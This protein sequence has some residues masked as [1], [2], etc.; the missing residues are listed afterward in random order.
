[1][2]RA[3][4]FVALFITFACCAALLLSACSQQASKPVTVEVFSDAEE[5]PKIQAAASVP[6]ASSSPAPAPT[7]E[8]SPIPSP[9]SDFY[10]EFFNSSVFV[11][12]SIT[13]GLQNYVTQMRKDRPMLLGDAKFAAAKSFNLQRACSSRV[14]SD[15]ALRYRGKAM[16][17]PGIIKE[18]GVN[19]VYIMLGVND[20]AGSHID[21]CDT[22][23]RK[24]LDNIRSEV[25]EVNIHVQSCTPVTKAG[26]RA[27]LNNENLDGFNESLRA[28]CQ[29]TGAEYVE[30]S[31]AL[32]GEDNCM[33]PEYSSDHYV[34]VSKD[35]ATAWVNALYQ[36]AYDAYASGAWK[37]SNE[38]SQNQ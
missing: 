17:I 22:L 11:G 31:A 28:I 37:P 18:M 15:G 26:E 13:Q 35:G 38:R 25:P 27:K 8:P 21:E 5:T 10:D 24:L 36:Y 32:K 23:Y 4:V 16:T 34:H 7:P 29:D 30:I 20:W 19:N 3:A 2:K 9:G 14:P 12:D 33:K 6:A 1:M